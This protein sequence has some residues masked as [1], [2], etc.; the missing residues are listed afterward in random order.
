[1]TEFIRF[2]GLTLPVYH[3]PETHIVPAHKL[4]CI[5]I[6]CR[7]D[8]FVRAVHLQ[9]PE[10]DSLKDALDVAETDF[11]TVARNLGA[12][13]VGHSWG[14][15]NP[16]IVPTDLMPYQEKKLVPEGLFLVAE[17][18]VIRGAT[19]V[20]EEQEKAI[21]DEYE[22]HVADSYGRP[23]WTEPTVSQFVNGYHGNSCVMEL[24][25]VDIEPRV[26]NLSEASI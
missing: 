15:Y 14:L 13:V 9:A 24:W 5:S 17:V 23:A 2:H 16:G 18:D 1:M 26:Y 25:M 11:N 19:P 22:R 12:K 3:G 20:N 8:T 7:D 4:P 21:D 6:T 10:H